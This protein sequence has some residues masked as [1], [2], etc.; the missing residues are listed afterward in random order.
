MRCLLIVIV[1]FLFG[2]NTSA[3]TN[4]E[5]SAEEFEKG[6][7]DKQIQLLDVRTASEFRS[8]Y[9]KNALQANWNDRTEFEKRIAALDKN[10]P[11]YIYCLS[12]PRSSAAAGWLRN[13]GFVNVV[14]LAGGF[15]GWK[16]Q[17][18]PVEGMTDVKQMTLAEYQQ[19]ITGKQ[20]VLVNFGAEWCPP[21]RKMEPIINEFIASNKNVT[22]LKIDGGVHT[23]LMKQ[24]KVEGIPTLLFFK[25]GAELWR[26]DG[27]VEKE[28][29][30][31][32]FQSKK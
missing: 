13:K 15:S 20:Y 11:V 16:R 31:N 3:Q 6:L 32:M 17:G 23:D 26:K 1:G 18:K 25:N 22:L 21:C 19:Q 28:E 14:E 4:T 7:V 29:L 2:C 9:I 8:G 12:G 24:L 30:N 10:K 27:V 5:V